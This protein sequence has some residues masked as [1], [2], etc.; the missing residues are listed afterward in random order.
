MSEKSAHQE[1]IDT[2]HAIGGCY[3]SVD[4]LPTHISVIGNLE[5]IT[6]VPLINDKF[7][8]EELSELAARVGDYDAFMTM[9][10]SGFVFLYIPALQHPI[11]EWTAH[12]FGTLAHET[13]HAAVAV[14]DCVDANL[15]L[16]DNDEVLAYTQGYLYSQIIEAVNLHH[17]D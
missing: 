9:T 7:T 11:N 5:V 13:L 10:E 3:V 12:D 1:F 15:V 6:D 17:K 2:L 14:W 16:P 4:M 8:A